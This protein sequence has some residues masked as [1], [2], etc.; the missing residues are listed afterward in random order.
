MLTVYVVLLFFVPSNLTISFLSSY[1]RPAQ[2]WGLLLAFWWLNANLQRASPEPSVRR[3]PLRVAVFVFVVVV[4]VS[5]AAAM[6][7][8][9]PY[10]QVSPALSALVRLMS[11]TGVL[12][13]AMDGIERR[14]DLI[15]LVRRLVIIGGIL[16]GLGLAQF[17]SGQT[18]LTWMG[19]LPG[20]TLEYGGVDARGT[21]TRPSGTATHP[22]EYAV[23]IAG[24][25]PFTLVTATTGGFRRP[26]G[27]RGYGWWIPVVLIAVSSLVAVS[28]S[29]ILGLIVAVA[30]SMPAL[31]R[32]YR[33][34]VA[35]GGTATAMIVAAA[36]PGILGTVINLFAGSTD[37][38]STQSRADALERVPDFIASSPFIGQGFGIFL[39]R[40][41]IF[42]NQWA[43]LV[44][45]VG[46]LGAIAFA[47]IS[48]A[49]IFTAVASARACSD[50]YV[51][52]LGRS[53]AASM[54]TITVMYF[55]FDALSF[56]ISAGM[57]FLIA[58]LGGA[59]RRVQISQ[60]CL[61]Q[62]RVP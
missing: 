24:I 55:L 27:P 52:V 53:I 26:D 21:F 7:R 56:P 20:V 3:Q 43:L 28:R 29:A 19:S 62:D 42:D 61:D 15:A 44:V 57:F 35:V 60:S 25:L 1:G 18:L 30:A 50:P 49:S 33:W 12:L 46:V 36:G 4:L 31:P 11:W 37:D 9:Q 8:G 34:L 39:P 13:V 48:G 2:L 58:G 32:A 5:F 40:Y 6:L 54:I 51:K 16:A 14:D 22:L 23:T 10:D 59:M 41:Y 45:E 38:P 17:A 47:C